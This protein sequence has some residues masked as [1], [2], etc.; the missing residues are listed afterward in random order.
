MLG[1]SV[2]IYPK[3]RIVATVSAGNNELFSDSPT[4]TI[5]RRHLKPE[6]T[7]NSA[8]RAALKRLKYKTEHFY[9]SRRTVF[10]KVPEQGILA[11]LGFRERYP[12][13]ESFTPLLGTYA[14][15]NNNASILPAFV[16]VMQNNYSGGIESFEFKRSGQS[17]ILTSVEGGVPYNVQIGFYGYAESVLDFS[18][19]KYKVLAMAEHV[20]D[21]ERM[22]VY[23]IELIFPELPNTR[24]LKVNLTE[25]GILVNMSE[26][27]NE[28]VAE[29]FFES[30]SAEG[31]AGFITG[32]I[33]KKM[34]EGFIKNKMHAIFNPSLPAID[35]RNAGFRERLDADNA[36]IAEAN[37]KSSKL[38]KTLVS[39]FL[40]DER[41]PDDGSSGG[42]GSFFKNALSLLF[43]V[44]K[45][46]P[47]DPPKDTIIEIPDDAIVFLDS[48]DNAQ[49]DT[50]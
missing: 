16:S 48:D 6:N 29:K 23:K 30:M 25:E 43:K 21:E 2:W 33:E 7:D 50:R 9:K 49:S 22:P 42:I 26:N 20:T 28:R 35:V 41:K 37:E 36:A 34:G 4:L 27:P 45:A 31:K 46:K 12:F 40:S 24:T 11:F 8:P 44:A 47:T 38:I 3:E 18:G 13:D 39:S 19:E 15:R 32:F 5:I 14:T 17:L 10:P 1:Q